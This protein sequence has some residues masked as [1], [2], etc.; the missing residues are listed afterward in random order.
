MHTSR[1]G[2]VRLRVLLIVLVLLAAAAGL[3]RVRRRAFR[4]RR[5]S[6]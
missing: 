4:L 5:R 1:S 6:S 3:T 2:A